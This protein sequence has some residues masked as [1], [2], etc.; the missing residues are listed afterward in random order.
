MADE[1]YRS[2]KPLTQRLLPAALLGASQET[3]LWVPGCSTC[4]SALR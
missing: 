1:T 3:D 4:N 2:F